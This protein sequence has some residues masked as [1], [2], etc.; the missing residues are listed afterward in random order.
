MRAPSA[1]NIPPANQSVQPAT[2][3]MR[4]FNRDPRTTVNRPN[5][6]RPGVDQTRRPQPLT[7][8][9]PIAR[10]GIDPARPNVN[11]PD[12]ARPSV[13]RPELNRPNA[14]RP[15]A[16]R[17]T[18]SRP[19]V[20]RPNV[21]RPD[22][23]RPT[24]RPDANRPNIARP[25]IPRPDI[26]RPGIA[27]PDA[28]RPNVARPDAGR[29][30]V[31]RPNFDRPGDRPNVAGGNRDVNRDRSR[32][33]DRNR[34]GEHDRDRDFARDRNRDAS[35]NFAARHFTSQGN[36]ANVNRNFNNFWHNQSGNHWRHNFGNNWSH[37]NWY[38]NFN[39]YGYSVNFYP[40]WGVVP[41]MGWN[42]GGWGWGW[43]WPQWGWGYGGWG[44]YGYGYGDYATYYG[45]QPVQVTVLN[46]PPQQTVLAP[47]QDQIANA[48]DFY[49]RAVQSFQAGQYA[50]ALRYC[51]HAMVDYPQNGQVILLMGHALLALG[52]NTEAADA[53]Q[54]AL[55][56]LPEDQ[57]GTIVR[58]YA[59]YYPD[60]S[61]YT[62]QLRALEKA[63]AEGGNNSDA[64]RFLLAYQ[65]G[66]L[67]H[68]QYSVTQLDKVV[69]ARP[70][71]AVALKL[72]NH[73]AAERGSAARAPAEQGQQPRL[74]PPE[75]ARI[76]DRPQEPRN[77][78]TAK[79]TADQLDSAANFISDGEEEF[80]AGRY[81]EAAQNWQHALVDS[82]ANGAVLLLLSQ[83]LFAL[84]Q[85]SDAAGA[86]QMAMQMLPEQEWGNVVNR[87]QELYGDAQAYSAQIKA[88]E[89]ARDAKT[90]D[91][92]IR[93][94]LGYQLG[95]NGQT[96][97]AVREL[98][99]GLELQPKDQGAQRLKELFS[100]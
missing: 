48:D 98:G 96:Q 87:Q 62:R 54:M 86:V 52:Q 4:T 80:K 18:F 59:Q 25:N 63:V 100:K 45:N 3:S 15:D 10:P 35:H 72:R 58:N 17:P 13:A 32:D 66:F 1:R 24:T 30:E 16:N 27:R 42:W 91:P 74:A 11:R 23:N 41:G 90:D 7:E 28:G 34:F 12:V 31:N 82:P 75:P 19:D 9:P 70:Q 46:S 84:G 33:G 92:A 97:Q 38:R 76:A 79:P 73:F 78:L 40:W 53:I 55:E 95:Y 29:R 2:P 69:D 22:V 88:L 60:V 5:F 94:L 56:V 8:R 50:E 64:L 43:G 71:D 21:A 37:S 39:R 36:W 51:Q 83:A 47:T 81:R 68:Q 14:N 77:V 20:N 26:N 93:F 65:Y 99:K 67:G 85:Y 6:D 61:E 49:D 89:Q 44:G 57:W